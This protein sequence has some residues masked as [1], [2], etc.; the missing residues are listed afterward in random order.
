MEGR[1]EYPNLGY[2]R[3]QFIDGINTS[4]VGRVVQ[5]RQVDILFEGSYNIG[6]YWNAPAEIFASM[7]HAVAYS[8]DLM[9]VVDYSIFF[10]SQLFKNQFYACRVVGN[11]NIKCHFR[12]INYIVFYP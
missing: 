2:S 4:K 11:R 7:N 3:Q 12:I 5:G 9:N 1:I 6:C 8:I 10:V